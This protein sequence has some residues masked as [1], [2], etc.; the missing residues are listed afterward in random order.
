MFLSIICDCKGMKR[1]FVFKA[2]GEIMQ[3]RAKLFNNQEIL[4]LN[5]KISC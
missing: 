5:D 1:G 3:K 2:S 4:P